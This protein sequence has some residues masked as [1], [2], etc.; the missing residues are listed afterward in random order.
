MVDAAKQAISS[1]MLETSID[2]A[3]AVLINIT[4]GP[5]T[6]II[7]INEAAQLITAAADPEA[8]IIFGAGIDES[9]EDEVKITVIATGF[10]KPSFTEPLKSAPIG[11]ARDGDAD[12]PARPRP[13]R[14]EEEQVSPIFERRARSERPPRES[15]DTGYEQREQRRAER[16]Q[17]RRPRVYQDEGAEPRTQNRRGFTPDVPSFMKKK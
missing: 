12:A 10:E 8:N 7:D 17:T 15:A 5:D 14:Y 6:S 3:R 4:G 2:G 1:P 13:S 16:Q 11:E 9:M